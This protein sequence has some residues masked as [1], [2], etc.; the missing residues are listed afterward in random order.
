MALCSPHQFSASLQS[1]EV[2]FSGWLKSAATLHWLAHSVL[3]PFSQSVCGVG[4]ESV[5]GDVGGDTRT[6]VLSSSTWEAIL[7]SVFPNFEKPWRASDLSS[8]TGVM[9]STCLVSGPGRATERLKT[10]ISAV[11]PLPQKSARALRMSQ[12][13]KLAALVKAGVRL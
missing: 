9:G 4:V 13:Q 1:Y 12:T 5:W 11:H 10:H 7:V 8:Q 3:L 6:Q 2:W